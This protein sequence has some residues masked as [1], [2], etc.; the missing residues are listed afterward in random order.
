LYLQGTGIIL[1]VTGSSVCHHQSRE[2]DSC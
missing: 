2:F 1:Y